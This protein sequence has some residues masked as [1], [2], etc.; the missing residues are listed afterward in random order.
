M[1]CT[2]CCAIFGLLVSSGEVFP[3][4][5]PARRP[6]ARPRVRVVAVRWFA[7][8]PAVF[9]PYCVPVLFPYAFQDSLPYPVWNLVA[10]LPT[11]AFIGSASATHP[12][13][14][15]KDGTTYMVTDY[16]RVNDQLH[17]ITIEEGGMKS[18]PH[19]V[20]FDDLDVQRTSDADAAQGFRFVVRGEPIE[21]WLEHHAQHG[22]R[23]HRNNRSSNYDAGRRS[24]GLESSPS[25]NGFKKA[26]ANRLPTF[27]I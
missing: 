17:F 18:V 23:R 1:R 4:G 24:L 8:P 2:I 6:V 20:P 9:V 19:S 25:N 13:L 16:W 12:Q 11:Y 22:P 5:H 10:P 27:A 14:V 15:F 26:L 7:T 3:Q 21:Q